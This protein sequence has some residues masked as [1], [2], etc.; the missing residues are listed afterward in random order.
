MV[1]QHVASRTLLTL[2]LASSGTAQDRAA[3]DARVIEALERARPAL[4]HH[5]ESTEGDALTLV[6]LAAAH[7]GLSVQE[8]PFRGALHRLARTNLSNAYALAVRLMLMVELGESYPDHREAAPRDTRR[9]LACQNGSAGFRYQPHPKN[10]DYSV[11]QYA[12]L[13]LRAAHALDVQVPSRV[14]S[15]VASAAIKGR[16]YKGGFGYTPGNDATAS[17][18]VAGIAILEVCKARLQAADRNVDSLDDCIREAWEWMEHHKREIQPGTGSVNHYFLYGLERAAIL[19]N[20]DEVGG[21]DWYVGGAEQILDGQSK[22]GG[23]FPTPQN[24]RQA[25]HGVPGYGMPVQTSFAIL[26]LKRAF[27]RELT[28]RGPFTQAATV[29]CH[30]LPP[31][32]DLDAIRRAAHADAR[33]GKPALPDLL[34]ALRSEHATRRQAAARAVILITGEDFGY[35]PLR[36]PEANADALRAA[37]KWWLAHRDDD[38]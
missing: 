38:G 13:G 26:F 17:M 10:W 15:G 24:A 2:A 23:F 35:H 20:R 3:L 5:L 8:E 32:A 33:R 4:E 29:F 12:V 25:A 7:Y 31:D 27:R 34:R 19:S 6:C 37:E 1:A 18:T 30:A 28:P 14:W 22:S 21:V 36:S 9:L 16:A 11:T